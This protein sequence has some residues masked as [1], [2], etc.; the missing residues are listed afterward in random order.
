MVKSFVKNKL[1]TLS[2]DRYPGI[3]RP[4]SFP[5]LTGDSLRN[6]CDHVFDETQSFE[7]LEVKENDIVFLK[8]DL[9][10]IYFNYYHQSI[11]SKYI[12]VTH[13]SDISIEKEDLGFLDDKIKHWFAAKLNVLALK[14][15]TALP[16]GLENRRWLKNGLVKNFKSELSKNINKNERILCS[17][18][19]NTNLMERAP[20]VDIARNKQEIIDIR[21]FSESKTYIKEL[22]N[23]SFN[24]CPEGN[25]F[26]SHRI[27]ESLIFKTT[28]IVI[29]NIVNQNFYNMGIPLI[30][31][32]NWNDLSNLDINDLKRINARNLEKNYEIFVNLNFWKSQIISAKS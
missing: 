13:N 28:P 12:L 20:L 21:N 23:Y 19:A 32:D 25:N 3:F 29:N 14:K 18:N 11:K 30:M 9:K 24:L 1:R 5:F 4:S 15:L 31:L 16:Y 26:E 27:W 10:E 17:F 22:S 8:T 2:T 6:L 7:P